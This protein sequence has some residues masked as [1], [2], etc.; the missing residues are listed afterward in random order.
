VGLFKRGPKGAV[1][2]E[3]ATLR[4]QVAALQAQLDDVTAH[5]IETQQKGRDL[6]S[7]I[8]ALEAR[9][10]QVGSEITNQLGELSGDI[11][12]IERRTSELADSVNALPKDMDVIR[13]D[14][15]ELAREQARYQIAFRQDLAEAID[16]LKKRP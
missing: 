4:Q 16:M 6:T 9:I 1:A 8:G 12:G 10:T 14:Q 15:E 5:S 11:E 7:Q 13:H 3:L 2:A